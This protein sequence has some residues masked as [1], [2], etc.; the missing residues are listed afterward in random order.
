MCISAQASLKSFFT[1]LVSAGLLVYLGNEKLFVVN[2]IVA[3]FSIFTSFMQ[4]ID[5][6]MWIDLDCTKGTNKFASIIGPVIN[7]IQPV[8]ILFIAMLVF[9]LTRSG[10]KYYSKLLNNK[11]NYITESF[12]FATD[13]YNAPKM[14]S[15]V[16]CIVIAIILVKYFLEV[17][18]NPSLLCAQL[19][20]GELSWKWLIKNGSS[21][22]LLY[23]PVAFL[24]LIAIN[25]S[26][27]YT[28][29]VALVYLFTLIVSVVIDKSRAGELWCF[30][31]NSI[32][33]ILLIIQKIF[34][35]KLDKF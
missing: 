1:N 21:I 18:K 19:K 12:T 10:K 7:L 33:L 35:S 24:N 8:A 2:L 28:Y 32:P 22:L 29:I 5:Y 17:V 11:G 14:L 26:H 20:N 16:Y 30:T 15:F 3:L 4:L 13:K 31:S 6:M 9:K 23:L 27:P 25:P 34:K